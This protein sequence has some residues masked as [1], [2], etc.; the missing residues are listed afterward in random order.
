MFK[1]VHTIGSAF[2]GGIRREDELLKFCYLNSMN[3]AEEYRK[4]NN[5]D[6]ISI[7]FPCISTGVYRYPK[8]KA[9]TIAVNTVK[10]LNNNNITVY[11]VCFLE[12]NYK[13][14]MIYIKKEQNLFELK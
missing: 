3:L 1:S 7:A 14:I 9:A 10:S 8:D 11:F 6:K 5:L 12:E 2:S 4:I 13:N